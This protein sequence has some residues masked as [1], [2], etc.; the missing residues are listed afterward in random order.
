MSHEIINR[1]RRNRGHTQAPT[2][3]T[4][5]GVV[6]MAAVVCLW[7]VTGATTA[8]ATGRTTATTVLA[9]RA[10]PAAEGLARQDGGSGGRKLTVSRG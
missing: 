7:V 2:A 9:R 1:L 10:T 8:Q 5:V 4:I 3:A 6:L